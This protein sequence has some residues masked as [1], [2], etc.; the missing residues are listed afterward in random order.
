LFEG[1][2]SGAADLSQIALERIEAFGS[3]SRFTLIF[4]GRVISLGDVGFILVVTGEM[5]PRF[6]HVREFIL[7]SRHSS[8]SNLSAR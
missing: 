1:Q 4:G 5:P 3:T 6:T 2:K 7:S 8:L